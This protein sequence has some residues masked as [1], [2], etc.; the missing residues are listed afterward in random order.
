MPVFSLNT[1]GKTWPPKGERDI[2]EG[3]VTPQEDFFAGMDRHLEAE[4]D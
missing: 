4:D 3:K 2:A 1:A